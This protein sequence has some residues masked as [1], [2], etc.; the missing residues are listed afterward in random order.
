MQQQQQQQQQ[1][2]RLKQQVLMQQ[3]LMQQ[4]LPQ[5]Q[6]Q[7]SLYPHPG[8]LAPPQIEPIPSGNLP[9][10]FDSSTCR[11]VCRKYSCSSHGRTSSRGFPK[12]W[13]CRR[14]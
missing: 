14:M 4:A 12:Y 7:Q 10:G 11:S 9:P 1:Q 13:S 3:A 2:Q 8:L 6:Q 5:Q